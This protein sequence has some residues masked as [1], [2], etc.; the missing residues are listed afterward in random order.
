MKD[1]Y[2]ICY[3]DITKLKLYKTFLDENASTG[4]WGMF[5]V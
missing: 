3:T 4:L 2:L 1:S 5:R